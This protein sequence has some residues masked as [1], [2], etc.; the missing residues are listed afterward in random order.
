MNTQSFAEQL[1]D[2]SRSMAIDLEPASNTL[3][4]A[5]GGIAGALG[6]PPFEFFGLTRG[7]EVKKLFFRDLNQS[8]YH[9]GLPGVADSLI[10]I[11]SALEDMVAQAGTSRLVMV[12]NSMGGYA[13]L[14]FGSWLGAD[15][16]HAFCPQTFLGWL[17]RLKHLDF[18]WR[19]QIR[20]A[21]NSPQPRVLDLLPELKQRMAKSCHV[22][23]S[24][25]NR[26]DKAHAERLRS[27]PR[28]TLHM[29][30][31]GGHQLVKFLRDN[32]SL[33][34]ILMSSLTLQP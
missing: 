10:G 28:V 34:E 12:G 32:G 31:V 13:A 18:R 29:Y 4:V 8:W 11:R 9:R 25:T 6:M 19:R 30:P 17:E 23:Y 27:S 33:R 16:V 24:A 2:E 20:R 14:L 26:L 21:Q 5:W 7:L 3:L 1:A 22:Y 15:V